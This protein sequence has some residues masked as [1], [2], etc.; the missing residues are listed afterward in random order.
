MDIN[1]NK[2]IKDVREYNWGNVWWDK[3]KN[4]EF[5]WENYMNT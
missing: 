1:E 3:Y 5:V 4:K 2:I